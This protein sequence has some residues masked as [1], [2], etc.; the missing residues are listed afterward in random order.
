VA[1]TGDSP[2]AEPAAGYRGVQ[3]L[4]EVGE[5]VIDLT[6]A[7]RQEGPDREP[8]LCRVAVPVELARTARLQAS[9]LP[10]GF[11]VRFGSRFLA[12]YHGTFHTSHFATVLVVGPQGAPTGFLVGTYDNACHY[13]WLVRHPWPLARSGMM[14]LAVR[15]GLAYEVLRTRGGRYLRSVIRLVRR[16]WAASPPAPADVPADGRAP[17]RPSVVAVLTHVAV[18]PAAQGTGAGRALVEAFV[19][20]A[21]EHGADEIR[22]IAHVDTPAPGFYRR[23]GWTSVGERAASDATLVEEF[24]LLL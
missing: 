6:E 1:R 19:R 12:A 3:P 17:A 8:P 15:P 9:Q 21:R 4:H 16:R 2:F 18:A 7:L 23:L 20:S 22:L 13:R 11:F 5:L 10:D 14:A 24:Q